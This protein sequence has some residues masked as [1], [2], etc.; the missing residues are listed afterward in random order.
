MTKYQP[1]KSGFTLVELLLY[2]T[3]LAVVITIISSFAFEINSGR[4]KVA[5]NLEIQENGRFVLQRLSQEI[6]E[7]KSIDLTKST[8]NTNPGKLALTKYN[9]ADT[10]TIFEIR[11][12]AL[13]IMQGTKGPYALTSNEV[14]I[15]NLTFQSLDILKSPENIKITLTLKHLN[16][17]ARPDWDAQMT[18]EETVAIR[19]G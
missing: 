2:F 6:K 4:M 12:N 17:S 8:L 19:Q 14:I 1:S 13:T 9:A 7:A 5:H 15:D 10:P 11:N 3:I 18:W 16:P